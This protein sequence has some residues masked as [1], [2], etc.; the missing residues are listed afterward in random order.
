MVPEQTPSMNITVNE[1]PKS[2]FNWKFWLV[3]AIL[4]VV[5]VRGITCNWPAAKKPDIVPVKVEQKK[6]AAAEKTMDRVIDSLQ[7][8]IDS[9]AGAVAK[10]DAQVQD[11]KS[12]L[13]QSQAN[14]RLMETEI[15]KG[16]AEVDNLVNDYVGN[17]RA[18]DSLCNEV[19]AGQEVQ[20]VAKDSIITAK[21]Q[22]IKARD[23]FTSQIR[24]SFDV[25][26]SNQEKQADYIKNLN[27]QLRNKKV[28]A[29]IWKGAAVAAGLYIL[30]TIIVKK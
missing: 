23:L 2:K 28:G 5:L 25:V 3:A 30:K 9:I 19:I 18:R 29:T 26:A 21:D 13:K 7:N 6:I 10:R 27:R 20:I 1:K 14:A 8:R 11:L 24:S 22:Q 15:N 12:R 17:S 16:P 4:L